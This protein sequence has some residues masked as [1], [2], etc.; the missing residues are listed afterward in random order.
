MRRPAA[1]RALLIVAAVL[2]AAGVA[3][4][5]A[6]HRTISW[7]GLAIVAVDLLLVLQTFPRRRA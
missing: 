5:Y 6:I 4:D 3:Y 7:P 1:L 2:V